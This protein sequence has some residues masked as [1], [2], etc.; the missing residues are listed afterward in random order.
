M[1]IDSLIKDATS[2]VQDIMSKALGFDIFKNPFGSEQPR[3]RY[4]IG[5]V[6]KHQ[7]VIKFEAL[8]RVKKSSVLDFRVP[9]FAK[10]ALGSVVLYMPSGI[11]VGDVLSYDNADTGIGGQ[12]ANAA[13]GAESI[14][15]FI[16]T[17]K[18]NSKG[19]AQS[20]VAYALSVASQEKGLVGGAA[21]QATIN[22][23][24]VLNPHTQMLFKAPMLRQFQ[25]N[26]KMLPKSRQE[27]RE[28]V[29]IVQFF[30]V[31]AYPELGSGGSG[32]GVDMSTFKFP[33]IFKISYLV[34][35]RE[36]KNMIR[37]MESYLTA[38]TVNYNS[39]SPTFYEDGMPSEV[40]LQ[41]TFMESK[42]INRN[43]ILAE[44]Y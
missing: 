40:D 24:E 2:G 41:L 29:K 36:N 3:L 27:A 44:G 38:V 21:Q 18:E 15:G 10:S 30:R 31:A 14:G 11:T 32:Q 33:D 26:F 13:G 6:N 7:N 34:D 22:R 9:Q 17:M 25:F 23:G 42:A 1:N 20:G 12:L 28:I 35:G 8:T 4:P 43:L 39:N 19:L 5:D 16:D 37:I